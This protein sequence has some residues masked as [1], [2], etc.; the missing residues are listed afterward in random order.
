V[1]Q[2]VKRWALAWICASSVLMHAE[3]VHKNVEI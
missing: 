3:D 2:N 1:L